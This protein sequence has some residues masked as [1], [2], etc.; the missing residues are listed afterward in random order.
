V[1]PPPLLTSRSLT[2]KHY[3]P[4]QPEPQ[5]LSRSAFRP[6]VGH[7]STQHSQV[8]VVHVQVPVSQQLQQSHFGQPACGAP[9]TGAAAGTSP[10]AAQIKNQSKKLFM[11]F[12]LSMWNLNRS[13]HVTTC[14]RGKA[15]AKNAVADSV[16]P[17]AKQDPRRADRH[18]K[19]G[20]EIFPTHADRLWR[21]RRG[22][23]EGGRLVTGREIP[24]RVW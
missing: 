20:R 5:Q 17:H 7:S 1:R 14:E 15:R 8:H 10:T 13:L 21:G 12:S 22:R 3:A 18:G 6:A 2:P 23:R 4:Q 24:E 9:S 16:A 11:G 19:R